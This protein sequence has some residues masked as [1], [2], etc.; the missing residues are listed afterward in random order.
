M[1]P[2]QANTTPSYLDQV[3][4][5]MSGLLRHHSLVPSL[6]F[7]EAQGELGQTEKKKLQ[8]R[9]ELLQRIVETAGGVR[10]KH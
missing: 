1:L 2:R 6:P 9:E 10:G 4:T 8:P 3:L 5:H 7:V